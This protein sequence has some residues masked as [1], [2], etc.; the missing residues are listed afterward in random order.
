MASSLLL[1][2]TTSFTSNHH[3]SPPLSTHPSNSISIRLNPKQTHRFQKCFLFHHFNSPHTIPFLLSS[4]RGF[5]VVRT[6][7]RDA[8]AETEQDSSLV[9]EDSA[10]FELGQQKLSSWVYFSVI[11]GTVLFVLN[12]AWI[13][14]STG[15]GKAFVDAVSRVSDSHEVVMLIL[16]LIFACVHS[17]LASLRDSGE[18]LIG[19][20]AYRVL[21]AGISLPLAL[22]T[23]VYFINHRYDGVQLWQLQSAPG[24][25]ELVWISNFISFFF[26]YPSTFNLLEVAAVDK[27]KLHLW[28]TGIIR[29][30]RH[31]QMVGQVMW[32]LAHTIW[33]GN[34]VAI[35]ASIGLI[36]HHLF[37]V[38]NGDRKLALRYGEDF[39]LVKGR[40]S[41]VPF[42]AI[43]DR[44]QKLPKD[45]YKEFIRVPYLAITAMTL[46]AYF[47][48]PL[49]QAASFRLHW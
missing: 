12:V 6:S 20:R 1:S 8:D 39:E 33:I 13:D 32:C 46:G 14:D 22:S 21:F 7:I 43:I 27:P 18:K 48:H 24:V 9:G 30:T 37:G 19:E 29:I 17:G 41:V 34:S 45:F 44:R 2:T 49:M 4:R 31:P 16:I 5:D 36:A 42:A 11:L 3:S 15:F 35:A 10:A 28:E 26:L 23:I 40:T 38:W 25:H 47:A